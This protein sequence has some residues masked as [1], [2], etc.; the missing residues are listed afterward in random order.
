[1]SDFELKVSGLKEVQRSLYSYSRQLGDKVV[2]QA[3]LEGA[4]LMQKKA[5]A[6]APKKTG[7]LRRGIIVKKSRI[8]NGKRNDLLG[9]YMTLR[10]GKG[11]ADPKDA[12]YGR[13]QE[14]GWNVKGASRTSKGQR[15]EIVARF[16]KR[17]GRKTL[18]GNRDIPGKKFMRNAFDSTKEASA[19]LIIA[20]TERGSEI[21]KRRLGLK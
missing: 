5:R 1:V 7:R 11:K 3:L 18:P 19:Q 16:G 15:A 21:L 12:F 4:K 20:A 9:V 6:N 14:D 13:F 8:N 10:T 17:T 2:F